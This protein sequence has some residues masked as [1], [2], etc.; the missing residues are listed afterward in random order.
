MAQAYA[1]IPTSTEDI[2]PF[3]VFVAEGDID[4][5]KQLV[6]LSK[7]APSTYENTREDRRY[8]VTQEWLTAARD[9]WL[10]NFD[11]RACEARIN[12]FPNFKASIKYNGDDFS[13]HFVALFSKKSDAVPVISIHGWPGAPT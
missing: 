12:S 2:E 4:E 11:W 6:K 1:N 7:I 10:T 8:G 5:C 9:Y 3:N 13:V